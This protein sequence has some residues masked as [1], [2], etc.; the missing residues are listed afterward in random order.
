I[1]VNKLKVDPLE[2]SS[3]PTQRLEDEKNSGHQENYPTVLNSI[4]LL[5]RKT[6]R[7]GKYVSND[8]SV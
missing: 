7:I 8:L 2:T 4:G 6:V 1:S 5:L 3:E